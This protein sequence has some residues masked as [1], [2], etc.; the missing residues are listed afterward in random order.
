M[1]RYG[2]HNHP[3]GG[4]RQ[5]TSVSVRAE[6]VEDDNVVRR[7][8]R[9]SEGFGVNSRSVVEVDGL[10][11]EVMQGVNG[12][13]RRS[14]GTNNETRG[15]GGG[16]RWRQRRQMALAEVS[17]SEPIGI[18]PK[19]LARAIRSQPR[20]DRVDGAN[21]TSMVRDDVEVGND[22]DLEWDR[23]VGTAKVRSGEDGLDLGV[24]DV[25]LDEIVRVGQAEGSEARVVEG[26]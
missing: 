24:D 13:S 3:R 9:R 7:W 11:T 15:R 12:G 22:I 26:G 18:V 2:R 23:H 17:N 1:A 19:E 14:S 25:R 6:R 16:S 5:N 4:P 10:E 21:E 20:D 8:E